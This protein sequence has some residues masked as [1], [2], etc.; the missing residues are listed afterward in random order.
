MEYVY[1]FQNV[2]NVLAASCSTGLITLHSQYGQACDA[3]WKALMAGTG[4]GQ[5]E[6]ED[7]TDLGQGYIVSSA[8]LHVSIN[9]F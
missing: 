1:D 6:G 2:F 4:R 9:S 5:D 7:S 3:L 8:L